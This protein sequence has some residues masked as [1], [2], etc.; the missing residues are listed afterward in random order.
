MQSALARVERRAPAKSLT[1]RRSGTLAATAGRVR[2]IDMTV[3]RYRKAGVS[4]ISDIQRVALARF[5]GRLGG[6]AAFFVGVWGLAAYRFDAT[7]TEL[8][9]L[10]L[11]LGVSSMLGAAVAGVAIDRYG[12]TRVLVAAEIAYVP[13]ALS[14]TLVDSLGS[15]VAVVGIFGL[16]GAP[17]MTATTS[18][19]PYLV[20]RPEDLKK[21]NSLIELAGSASFVLGPGLGA[22]I[23]SV[24]SLDAV[25]YADAILTLVAVVVVASVRTPPLP[26]AERHH[27]LSELVQGL[28]VTYGK[29]SLRYYVLVGSAIWF[30]FGA[31]GALEPLFYRDAV[32]TGIET[33]GWMNSIFGV[34]LAL[35]AAMLPRLPSRVVCARGLAIGAA[36]I[37][38]G[39]VAYVGTTELA[40]IAAGALVWGLAIGAVEPLLRTLIHLDAPEEALGRVVGV[41]QLHRTAGELLP[42]AVA[43]WFAARFGVQAVLIGNGLVMTA[44]ALLSHFEA[45]RIDSLQPAHAVVAFEPFSPVDEPRSPNP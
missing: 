4:R 41:S 15:L 20:K 27:P 35:G 23:V 7:A 36:V 33:V 9:V 28:R 6:E 25:F 11:I 32:G 1:L 10:M 31:F 16:V 42:L 12:P 30:G 40:M 26:S 38:L 18:F 34:G 13:T 37:G 44:I 17:I 5:V 2:V 21:A 22:L 24:V 19:A 43:P 8:A 3:P 29:R 45:S 14:L 39:A